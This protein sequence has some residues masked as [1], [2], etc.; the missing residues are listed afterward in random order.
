MTNLM[1]AD[2]QEK[3]YEMSKKK[4]KKSNVMIYTSEHHESIP[5]YWTAINK[6]AFWQSVRLHD[7]CHDHDVTHF[8]FHPIS[9]LELDQPTC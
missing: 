4:K 1:T 7:S 3:S 8:L 5:A 6:E 9:S 2:E